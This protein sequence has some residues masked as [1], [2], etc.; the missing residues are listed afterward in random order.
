LGAL[1]QSSDESHND[2]RLVIPRL[3]FEAF[4][5]R[6]SH[7]IELLLSS[8]ANDPTEPLWSSPLKAGVVAKGAALALSV[9]YT[10]SL[11]VWL[12]ANGTGP[13]ARIGDALGE[14]VDEDAKSILALNRTGVLPI[15]QLLEPFPPKNASRGHRAMAKEIASRFEPVRTDGG[16]MFF[17]SPDRAAT[18]DFFFLAV[19]PPSDSPHRNMVICAYQC[20]NWDSKKNRPR[21]DKLVAKAAKTVKELHNLPAFA[22]FKIIPHFVLVYDTP[23]ALHNRLMNGLHMVQISRLMARR[24]TSKFKNLFVFPGDSQDEVSSDPHPCQ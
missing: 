14:I 11:A 9:L 16:F 3:R 7:D 2:F 15:A 4:I 10:S 23:I 17:Q 12:A 5:P 24:K 8:V 19:D 1:L 13:A 18:A 6:N 20:K 22:D 21:V